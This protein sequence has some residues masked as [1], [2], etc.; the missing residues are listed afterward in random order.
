MNSMF[1][2]FQKEN[3]NIPFFWMNDVISWFRSKHYCYFI[4][5][6]NDLFDYFSSKNNFYL[7]VWMNDV[8]DYFRSKLCFYLVV[9][10]NDVFD[11]FPDERRKTGGTTQV[12]FFGNYVVLWKNWKKKQFYGI[13]NT[14]ALVNINKSILLSYFEN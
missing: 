9:W 13:F 11:C 1:N 3:F 12:D 8:F 4:V 5:W 10:M 7:V 2:C 14:V 6:M